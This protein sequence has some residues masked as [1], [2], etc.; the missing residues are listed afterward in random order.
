MWRGFAHEQYGAQPPRILSQAWHI[1]VVEYA[2]ITER[3]GILTLGKGAIKALD[4]DDLI[5]YT[6]YEGKLSEHE[7]DVPPQSSAGGCLS[8]KSLTSH[9]QHRESASSSTCLPTSITVI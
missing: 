2:Q 8:G 5:L 7:L 1:L 4:L 3:Q 6:Q 9:Q